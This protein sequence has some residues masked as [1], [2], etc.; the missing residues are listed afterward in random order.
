MVVS[1]VLLYIYFSEV[2]TGSFFL[3]YIPFSISFL[4]FVLLFQSI[5]TFDS[6]CFFP[7]KKGLG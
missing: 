7:P 5:H 3:P 2:D 4:V 1:M 6:I